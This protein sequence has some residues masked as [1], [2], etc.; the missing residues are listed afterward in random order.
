MAVSE[1]TD[2][3]RQWLRSCPAL[4][5]TNRFG[6]DYLTQ[7]VTE[8]ALYSSPSP[9]KTKIDILGNVLYNNI[10]ELNFVFASREPYS[11]DVLQNLQNLGFFDEVRNW[12]FAQN[13]V[14]NFPDISEGEVISLLPST[15][16][17]IF[18]AGADNARYQ[19]QLKITYRR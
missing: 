5:D 9:V 2:N 12:I 6:V 7:D 4:D 19:I 15:T 13:T 14:K 3:L 1:T 11:V 17:F 16:Q 10:Q 8:Y 18:E